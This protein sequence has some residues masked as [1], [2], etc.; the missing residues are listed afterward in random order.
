MVEML[1]ANSTYLG[2]FRWRYV[3][4]FVPSVW[5]VCVCEFGSNLTRHVRWS[6]YPGCTKVLLTYVVN[7]LECLPAVDLFIVSEFSLRVLPGVCE[8]TLARYSAPA[9]VTVKL[10]H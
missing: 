1:K 8:F 3:F 6:L 5:C 9:V 2:S 4:K 7:I 10:V